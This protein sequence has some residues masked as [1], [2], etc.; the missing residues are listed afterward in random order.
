MVYAN[1]R[2]YEGEWKDDLREGKGYEKH[3]NGNIY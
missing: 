2:R 3:P 1:S